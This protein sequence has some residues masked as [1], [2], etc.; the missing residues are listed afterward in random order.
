MKK[1]YQTYGFCVIVKDNEKYGIEDIKGRIL[2]PSEYDRIVVALGLKSGTGFILC[3]NG[4]FGYVE[5]ETQEEYAKGYG[6]CA[7]TFLP[8]VYAFV[9]AK[10][11]GLAILSEG[12]EEEELWLDYKSRMLYRNVR[13]IKNF[14]SFD[15]LLDFSHDQCIPEIKKAG[16]DEW[17]KFPKN[18]S[19]ELIEQV[20]TDAYGVTCIL[21]SEYIVESEEKIKEIFKDSENE[22]VFEA[23]TYEE[24]IS[25]HTEY[26]ILRLYE[27]GWMIT[28]AQR[29][30]AELYLDVFNG[31]NSDSKSKKR[32]IKKGEEAY[33]VR[34]KYKKRNDK[35]N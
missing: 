4:R 9:E 19:V 1:T 20:H 7:K 35:W 3:K 11:N 29:T 5:F 18:C 6:G 22:A 8:C 2:L 12:R 26:S 23:E 34:A 30:L 28:R 13:W 10:R 16:A 15:A 14:G 33:S 21:C 32:E 31:E 17:V 24:I 27:S 25:E